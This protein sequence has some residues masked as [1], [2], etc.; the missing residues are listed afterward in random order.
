MSSASAPTFPAS[1]RPRPAA[2]LDRDGTLVNDPGFQRDPSAVELLPGAAA[3]V[4]RLNAAGFVVIVVTNQSGIARGLITAE[5]YSAVERRISERFAEEGARI[6]ATYHC[7]HY[8]GV[9]G[10]CE[11]RKPGTLLYNRAAE[12]WQLHLAS[13]W[14]VGDRVTDLEPVSAVGGQALLVRTGAGRKHESAALAAGFPVVPDLS[15]AVDHILGAIAP[16]G[17]P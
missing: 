12:E 2:F 9:G 4:A 5:E 11:C 13:S 8:P 7:P 14:G 1:P 16:P 6:D 15:A 3:A 17:N 10:P